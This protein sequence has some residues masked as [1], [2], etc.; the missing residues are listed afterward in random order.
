MDCNEKT[1]D[2]HEV[3]CF[4]VSRNYRALL[5]VALS[6]T[7]DLFASAEILPCGQNDI[8]FSLM[9]SNVKSKTQ[10]FVILRPPQAVA[11]NLRRY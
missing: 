3:R 1:P 2:F 7:A 6:N 10:R 9:Q 4:S 11:K 5:G 8:V